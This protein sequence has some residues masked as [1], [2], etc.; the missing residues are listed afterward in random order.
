[1]IYSDCGEKD[2]QEEVLGTRGDPPHSKLSSHEKKK[3]CCTWEDCEGPAPTGENQLSVRTKWEK[4]CWEKRVKLWVTFTYNILSPSRTVERPGCRRRVGNGWSWVKVLMARYYRDSDIYMVCHTKMKLKDRLELILVMILQ[5]GTTTKL[6]QHHVIKLDWNPCYFASNLGSCY[7]LHL[8]RQ[9]IMDLI[10]IFLT[11]IWK[12]WVGFI[13][14]GCY[15][16]LGKKPE[17][18]RTFSVS[19]YLCVCGVRVWFSNKV[20]KKF[21]EITRSK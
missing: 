21:F 4:E 18:E 9:Q 19:V 15:R 6:L 16:H 10:L 13:A 12:I 11:P 20:N 5:A 8:G 14:P 2:E 17:D 1:M 3:K 7:N